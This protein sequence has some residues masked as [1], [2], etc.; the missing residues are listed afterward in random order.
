MMITS[1]FYMHDSGTWK[2]NSFVY[3]RM[4]LL[5]T[6]FDTLMNFH[7]AFTCGKM[8]VN[9]ELPC[10]QLEILTLGRLDVH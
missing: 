1:L 9:Y 3:D 10:V 7:R 8:L 4:I 5:S 2:V 6:T